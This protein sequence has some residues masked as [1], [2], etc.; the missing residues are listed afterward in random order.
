MSPITQP[1]HGA[2]LPPPS[3]PPP[4]HTHTHRP[5][6]FLEALSPSQGF[7]LTFSQG[8]VKQP[9]LHEGFPKDFIPLQS[10]LS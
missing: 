8:P 7:V 4:P 6:P 3:P 10:L 1:P 2:P 5:Q 9:P